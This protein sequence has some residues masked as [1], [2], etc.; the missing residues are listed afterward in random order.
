MNATQT[1]EPE[2]VTP[3]INSEQGSKTILL[4]VARALQDLTD[5][6]LTM[7]IFFMKKISVLM[8]LTLLGSCSLLAF[9]E[10]GE[11][12]H[13]HKGK[14]QPPQVAIDACKNLTEKASCTFTGRNGEQMNGVCMLPPSEA[15]SSTLACRPEHNHKDHSNGDAAPARP[16]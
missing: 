11:G 2:E 15:G 9:A 16:Q 12:Q 6:L 1:T 14:H 13:S 5:S 8:S 7:R 4:A 10:D 3:V